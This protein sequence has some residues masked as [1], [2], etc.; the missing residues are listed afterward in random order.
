MSM[1]TPISAFLAGAALALGLGAQAQNI[2]TLSGG[3]N[4][5]CTYTSG[6]VGVGGNLT[7]TCAGGAVTAPVCTPT[8]SV[9]PVSP[10]GNSTLTANCTQSPSSYTWVQTPVMAGAPA[11]PAGASGILNFPAGGPYTY[12]VTGTN[13]AGTSLTAGSV[14]INVEA[15][16]SVPVCTP[17][18]PAINTGQATTI[19]ANCGNGPT[20]YTWTPD[21]GNPAGAPTFTSS[22]A[23]SFSI[24]AFATAGVYK[25]TVIATNSIGPSIPA[26][27]TVTVTDQV[28]PVVGNCVAPAAPPQL[29]PNGGLNMYFN[30]PRG[31]NNSFAAR[32]T[33]PASTT[34]IIVAMSAYI[35]TGTP[36]GNDIHAVVSACPGDFTNILTGAEG[37]CEWRMNRLGGS[38]NCTLPA[39]TYYL[40]ARHR[41]RTDLTV[42]SCPAGYVCEHVLN[43]TVP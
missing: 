23:A 11:A 24:G 35:T 38:F 32:Y 36:A 6:T 14:T 42:D 33:V 2:V 19:S 21:A 39:G 18:N 8:A 12:T 25:Y 5:S 20:T 9:N 17:N 29:V 13:S 10:N 41:K 26:T 28:V 15:P 22:A 27:S 31:L 16:T 7:F 40:N 1:R 37:P 3:T 43:I 30:A 34:P 4:A